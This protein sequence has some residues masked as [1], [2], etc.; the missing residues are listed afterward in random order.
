MRAVLEDDGRV[1][2]TYPSCE[3]FLQAFRPAE[4]ACLL[5]DAYL[6]GMSGL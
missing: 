3:A 1:V 2:E 4:S 6:P 5:I